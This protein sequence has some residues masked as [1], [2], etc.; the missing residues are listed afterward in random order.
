MIL[1]KKNLTKE[2]RKSKF[3]TMIC[4]L[5]RHKLSRHQSDFKEFHDDIITSIVNIKKSLSKYYDSNLIL[6]MSLQIIYI[7]MSQ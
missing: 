5:D 7:E 6:T 1:E 2:I 4:H 3:G